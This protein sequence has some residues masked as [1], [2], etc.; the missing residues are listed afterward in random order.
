LSREML[1]APEAFEIALEDIR[2]LIRKMKND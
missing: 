1:K 2:D